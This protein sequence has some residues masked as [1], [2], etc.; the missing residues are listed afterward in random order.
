MEDGTE[1]YEVKGIVNSRRRN[2]KLEYLVEWKGYEGTDEAVSWQGRE[3]L[4]G[5]ADASITEFHRLNPTK[6]RIS[7]APKGNKK[8]GADRR[9][10]E[11]K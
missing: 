9:G 3:N 6:P 4:A 11:K 1:E 2:G 10:A 5:T 8:G 7:E